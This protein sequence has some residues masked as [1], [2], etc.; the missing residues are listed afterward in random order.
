MKDLVTFEYFWDKTT[1]NNWI[2]HSLKLSLILST[3]LLEC[4]VHDLSWRSMW[5]QRENIEY[6]TLRM[7]EERVERW[8]NERRKREIHDVGMGREEIKRKAWIGKEKKS[9]VLSWQKSSHVTNLPPGGW[10]IVLRNSVKG[11]SLVLAF[12]KLSTQ[13][14]KVPDY[15]L[16]HL[17]TWNSLW[18][19][20]CGWDKETKGKGVGRGH[21]HLGHWVM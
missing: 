1:D 8:E 17:V 11:L 2:L 13:Q 15:L 5:H 4:W 9:V 16:S 7:T 18:G 21:G 20:R 10:L 19:H 14:W 12:G 6:D 3:V